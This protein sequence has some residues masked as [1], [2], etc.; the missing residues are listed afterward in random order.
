M[1]QTF[2]HVAIPARETPSLP[3]EKLPPELQRNLI[4]EALP[5]HGL[6]PRRPQRGVHI[7]RSNYWDLKLND[8]WSEGDTESFASYWDSLQ[9]ASEE[10]RGGATVPLNLLLVSKSVST[11]TRSIYDDEIPFVINIDPMCLHFLDRIV[12]E[13]KVYPTYVSDLPR[14][15][16]FLRLHNF[17]MNLNH[18]CEW[19]RSKLGV[20]GR[21]GER[22]W[23]EPCDAD[24]YDRTKPTKEWVRIA[25][26]LLSRNDAINKLTIYLPCFCGVNTPE[27]VARAEIA[28]LDILA[29]LNK[30]QVTKGVKFI[31]LSRE[32]TDWRIGHR[33]KFHVCMSKDSLGKD[34][35]RTLQTNLGQLDGGESSPQGE[36][37]I[38]GNTTCF[39]DQQKAG[40]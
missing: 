37:N 6:C 2:L 17:E 11:I 26:D 40:C 28:M 30:L 12:N 36:G 27:L 32:N 15:P 39:Q 10:V 1:V 22:I 31:W 24:R 35:L 13:N 5:D 14:Y 33:R 19:W 18:D 7:G 38:E 3:F 4:R 34:V 9:D 25:C 20:P 8:Y 23:C 16:H 21:R 29:P